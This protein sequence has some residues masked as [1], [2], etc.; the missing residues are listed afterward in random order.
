MWKV[1]NQNSAIYGQNVWIWW[2]CLIM[3]CKAGLGMQWYNY[4][5]TTVYGVLDKTSITRKVFT[6]SEKKN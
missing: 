5:R 6:Y 2:G 1:E 4:L 3:S